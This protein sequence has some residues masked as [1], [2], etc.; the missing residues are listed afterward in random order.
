ML[1]CSAAAPAPP[2]HRLPSLK[3]SLRRR[4]QKKPKRHRSVRPFPGTARPF[5]LFFQQLVAVDIWLPPLHSSL[6]S[7]PVLCG[8]P[9]QTLYSVRHDLCPPRLP[10]TQ[11]APV[12]IP[13]HLR[14]A[15]S[16]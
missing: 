15:Q 14:L 7:V 13:F 2:P 10:A 1:V 8:I 6:S 9:S 12:Y 4:R 5:F 16:P 3:I 11:L